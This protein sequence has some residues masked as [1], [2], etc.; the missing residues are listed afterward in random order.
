MMLVLMTV[1]PWPSY[2]FDNMDPVENM[3]IS[4]YKGLEA[5]IMAYKRVIEELVTWYFFNHTLHI[6]MSFL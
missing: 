6:P 3:A 4:S 2:A 5:A 1:I